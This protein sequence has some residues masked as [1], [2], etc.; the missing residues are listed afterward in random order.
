VS[1]S[2]VTDPIDTSFS[3][4]V[5]P[6]LGGLRL[7]CYRMLG[8]SH[9]SD[10][11]VQETLLRAWRARGSLEQPDRLKP[12]L[13]R[14][15]TNACLDELA[16]RPRR[17][18]AS[19]LRPAADPAL[20]AADPIDEALWL[21]PMPDTWLGAAPA[22]DPAARYTL[23]ESVA[24]AFIAALQVLSP[25]Q[26]A[27]LLLRDVVGMSAEEAAAA[28]D[29]SVSATHSALHRARTAIDERV[30]R[31]DPASFATL[32][33]DAAA[34]AGY[35]RAIAVCDVD[36]IIALMHD[37]LH[38]TMPPS[39]TW[40]AGRAANE[41]FYRRMFSSWRRGDVEVVP[42]G[43]NGQPGFTFHRGGAMRAVEVVELRDGRI[44]RMH[45]FMQTALLP[46]FR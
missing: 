16:R 11:L 33:A 44:A 31:R 18:L 10:D 13:Y 38:T 12:W 34:L 37:D 26:R 25:A 22:A 2:P 45:H 32:P 20:V 41:V 15:A 14:I 21:E 3:A 4:A 40:I 46:L 35:V 36:A 7:H 5:A 9:D 23:R 19:E 17:V 6:L 29:Q 8:S 1:D 24:L 42:V 30:A 43:A 28:L 39:P 27:A